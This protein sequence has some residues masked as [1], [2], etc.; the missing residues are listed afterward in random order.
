[1]RIW[2]NTRRKVDYDKTTRRRTRGRRSPLPQR[3]RPTRGNAGSDGDN[4]NLAGNARQAAG[5]GQWERERGGS[6]RGEESTTSE[7]G[8]LAHIEYS[9]LGFLIDIQLSEK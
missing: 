3:Q 5:S 2:H 7:I 6:A 9:K 4:L 8:Q 1:M